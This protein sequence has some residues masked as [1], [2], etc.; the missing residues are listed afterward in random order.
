MAAA[1]TDGCGLETGRYKR[2]WASA[3]VVASRL[4]VSTCAS[5]RDGGHCSMIAC[6][7]A[8]VQVVLRAARREKSSR[9]VGKRQEVQSRVSYMSGRLANDGEL[10]NPDSKYAPDAALPLYQRDVSI[11]HEPLLY[12]HIASYAIF[13]SSS[14]SIL[15]RSL[16]PLPLPFHLFYSSPLSS[17]GHLVSLVLFSAPKS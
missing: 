14:T 15:S 11:S 16:P 17:L 2:P 10:M 3:Q 9:C 12:R 7:F 8:I 13:F 4:S 5:S 6:T 1:G